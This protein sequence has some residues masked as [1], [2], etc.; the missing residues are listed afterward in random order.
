MHTVGTDDPDRLD[1]TSEFSHN[2][3][4]SKFEMDAIS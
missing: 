1:T 2:K 4:L 3:Q